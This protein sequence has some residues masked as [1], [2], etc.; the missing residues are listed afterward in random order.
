MA[1]ENA[2]A[3]AFEVRSERSGD[4]LELAVD[5]VRMAFDPRVSFRAS[6][7]APVSPMAA[8]SLAEA[9]ATWPRGPVGVDLGEYVVRPH[10]R[11]TV[12]P[13]PSAGGVMGA[14][15]VRITVA[16]AARAL[17]WT[18]DGRVEVAPALTGAAEQ[19]WRVD[20]LTDGA[21]RIAPRPDHGVQCPL[22]LVAVGAS[23]VALAPFDGRSDAGR[24]TF[25]RP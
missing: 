10:Q 1:G 8:Q 5:P 15:Y 3:G 19:L 17:A 11:W 12:T 6:P 7:D 9:S 16:G 21:Y 23:T 25:Q 18:R 2:P 24:W 22:A 4:A 14:P 13:V 20:Q